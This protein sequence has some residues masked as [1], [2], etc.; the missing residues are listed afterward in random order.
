MTL[1]LWEPKINLFPDIHRGIDRVFDNFFWPISRDTARIVWNPRVDIVENDNE[2][3]LHAELPGISKDEVKLHIEDSTLT[4]SGEKKKETEKQGNYHYAERIYGSFSR[5]FRLPNFVDSSKVKAV[6][7][8]GILTI[9]LPKLEEVKPK[10]I[11]I[12]IA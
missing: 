3:V 5:S 7:K 2:I 9:T 11:E 6:F 1:A 4:L 12:E 10:S 8:D